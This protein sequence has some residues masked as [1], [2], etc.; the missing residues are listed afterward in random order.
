MLCAYRRDE[1][2]VGGVLRVPCCATIEVNKHIVNVVQVEAE[3]K[4]RPGEVEIDQ[5]N[6]ESCLGA[7]PTTA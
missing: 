7:M 5:E 3:V 4:A 2:G 1:P 6:S